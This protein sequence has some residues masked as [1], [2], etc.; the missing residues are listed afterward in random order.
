MEHTG[1]LAM[2]DSD[3]WE[4][5]DDRARGRGESAVKTLNAI[6]MALVAVAV[7]D[8]DDSQAPNG[9]DPV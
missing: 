1:V 5:M 2:K 9:D 3:R 7:F 6:I 4:S 8:D